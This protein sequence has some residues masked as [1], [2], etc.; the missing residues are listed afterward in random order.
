[1]LTK[2]LTRQGNSLAL[3]IDKPVL[4]LLNIEEDTPVDMRIEGGSLIITP[5]HDPIR[6]EEL[7]AIL[8]KI[9][10]RHG[11]ALKRLAK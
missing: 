3:I 11:D 1:M 9:D 5:V 4:K 2:H 6:L 8:R 7:K 10:K